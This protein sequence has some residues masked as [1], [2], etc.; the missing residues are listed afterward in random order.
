[1]QTIAK[2][3]ALLPG[4]VAASTVWLSN[5]AC[6]AE[7]P[8]LDL[9][10]AGDASCPDLAAFSALTRAKLKAAGAAK[11]AR[12]AHAFSFGFTR[13]TLASWGNSS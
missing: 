13:K 7:S 6:A 5:S 4:L 8:A 10:Y 12:T 1:V 9:D 11:C 2:A 3:R